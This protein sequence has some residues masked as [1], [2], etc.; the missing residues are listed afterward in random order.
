MADLK[1][2]FAGIA[3]PNPFWL[4][5][6]PPTDKAYN[7]D[8]RVQG[9]LGR[10]GVEDARRGPADRQRQQPLWR[11]ELQRRADRRLQQ[12]RTDHRPA[13]AGEPGRD[14][15]DQA[16]LAGSRGGGQPDGAL[17]RGKLA[18]HPGAGGRDRLRRRG[19]EL[20]LPARHVGAQHGF[21]GRPGAGIRRD[22]HAVVQAAHADAGDRQADTERHRHPGARRGGAA[23]RRGWRVADQ[24]ACSRSPASIST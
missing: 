6:A 9:G 20:R 1:S 21:G 19:A 22:G 13:A 5:S 4:A 14:Q 10:R 3:S 2:N 11:R 12:Y 17:H 7:V 8:A 16:R 15:A 18:A 23:R 24:H